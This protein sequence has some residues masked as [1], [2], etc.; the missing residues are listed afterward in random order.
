VVPVDTGARIQTEGFLGG[1]YV[2]LIPGGDEKLL[3]N[4][5]TITNTQGA[6]VLE[7]R[8]TGGGRPAPR[9]VLPDHVARWG[10]ICPTANM[11]RIHRRERW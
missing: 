3:V 1:R 7:N 11:D 2:S 6:L 8:G 9:F 5:D 4:G 10:V